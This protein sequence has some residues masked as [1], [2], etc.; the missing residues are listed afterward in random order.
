MKLKGIFC[1]EL[2]V[3][4]VA[5]LIYGAV[6]HVNDAAGLRA[7]LVYGILGFIFFVSGIGLIRK[8]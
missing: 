8:I 5:G 3:L 7:L 4:G 6:L 1:S 2:T